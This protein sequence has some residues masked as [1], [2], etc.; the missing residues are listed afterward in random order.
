MEVSCDYC[1]A[2]AERPHGK[3]CPENWLYL[4]TAQWDLESGEQVNVVLYIFACSKD[5][6]MGLWQQGPGLVPAE[7]DFIELVGESDG[8]ETTTVTLRTILPS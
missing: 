4:E 3:L 6:A 2:K 8:G 1:N 7:E 5:C